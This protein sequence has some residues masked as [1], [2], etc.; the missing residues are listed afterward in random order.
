MGSLL[1]TSRSEPRAKRRSSPPRTT[2]GVGSGWPEPLRRFGRR[3]WR[4]WGS[5]PTDSSSVAPRAAGPGRSRSGFRVPVSSWCP[6]PAAATRPTHASWTSSC[7]TGASGNRPRSPGHVTSDAGRSPLGGQHGLV[8]RAAALVRA[9]RVAAV[10]LPRR[11]EPHWGRGEHGRCGCEIATNLRQCAGAE[12]LRRFLAM[13]DVP[14]RSAKQLAADIRK[15]KI[16]CLELLELY[17]SRVEKHDGKLNAIVVRDFD[18]ARKRARAADRALARRQA[19][20]PLHGVPMTIKESYD[21]TGLPTTWGVP[22]YKGRIATRNAVAVDRLLGAGAVLFGKTNVP[23]YLADW[24][25]FNAIYGTTNNPWDVRRAPGGSSGGSA[26]A[27]AAGLTGLEAGSD[28]G[29]S[30]RNP[31]HFCGVYGH[32]PTWGIVP[33]EGQ[34]L[35]WQKAPVDIDVVGPLAR[36]ADDLAL[37]LSVMA[38]PDEIEAAGWQLRLPP[39]KQKRLR[40]FKVALMLDAPGI[41]VDRTVM[42][43][44]QALADFLGKRKT[45]VDDRARPA[46][47][48]REAFAVYVRLLRAATSDRQNDAD[49]DRNVEL[50]RELAPDDESYYARATRAAVLSHR[51]WLAANEVRHRMRVAWAEFFTRYDLLL[52]P[53]AGTAA[54]PHDQKGERYDRTL[55][56]NGKRVP[57]TDHL[58]WAGYTGA[59]FLPST[60]APCGFT[61]SD[62]PVGVQ[63]VGPQYGDLTCLGF[64]QLLER[65]FQAFVPPPAFA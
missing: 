2:R 52:C 14:F 19:W 7:G 6:T 21:V 36:S 1:P 23:L 27:L 55:T 30:I 31:A 50:T 64:A 15:K 38:G 40:D 33:R 8:G 18:N 3:W 10:E 20:G 59:S 22:A 58:F 63:I 49:F 29:S 17:L 4:S 37:A 32:K 35:P 28:I 44:L 24:Q 65:E 12:P 61:P 47:D 45:T 54:F 41:P 62:L 5:P 60:A 9:G 26:A 25:S 57:V 56:V 42:D 11:N 39:P 48:T 51:D 53:V 13:L 16:G 43:R 46:I 34:A